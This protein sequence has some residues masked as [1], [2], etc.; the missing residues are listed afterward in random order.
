[1]KE[2]LDILELDGKEDVYVNMSKDKLRKVCKEK[3]V[4]LQDR[5]IL[6]KMVEVSKSDNLLLDFK[7]DGKMKDYLHE[8]P[9]TEA[10]I[11]F[12]LRSRMFPSKVNF[13]GRWKTEECEFCARPESDKHLFSC[14]GYINL[15]GNLNYQNIVNLKLKMDELYGAAV[16]MCKVKERIMTFNK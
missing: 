14:P 5:R 4:K 1:M 15:T 9:F 2:S 13:K 7:F 6:E 10:K 11:V 12:M 16:I 8:L 3:L